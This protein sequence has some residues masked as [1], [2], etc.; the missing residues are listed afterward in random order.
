[1]S[2]RYGGFRRRSVLGRRRRLGHF[3]LDASVQP[4][5]REKD[6][7]I[8]PLIGDTIRCVPL[9]FAV[10]QQLSSIRSR[11]GNSGFGVDAVG[12]VAV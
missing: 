11:E 5:R 4:P 3:Y 8:H 9:P 6:P 1:M 10:E 2:T 12:A 7:R